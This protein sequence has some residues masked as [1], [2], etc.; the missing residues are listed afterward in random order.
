[1]TRRVVSFSEASDRMAAR[2]GPTSR[3][4][5]LIDQ[6]KAKLDEAGAKPA[7]PPAGLDE[8]A[9]AL[10]AE[11][12]VEV[13]GAD[14]DQNWVYAVVHG[15]SSSYTVSHQPGRGWTC[16]CAAG[17]HNRRCSHL[18]AVELVTTPRRSA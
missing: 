7:T 2:Y 4:R 15:Y 16:A 9:K 18:I 10:L 14:R 3:G 13:R 5:A 12:R 6:A 11:G 17:A 8:K 1:M